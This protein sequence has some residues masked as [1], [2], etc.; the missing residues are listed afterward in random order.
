M[1]YQIAQAMSASVTYGYLVES[2]SIQNG[3]HGGTTQRT[4]LGST[5]II[6][7]DIITAIN[8]QR[9][10]NT[11]D[12]LSYLEQHTLPG[13]TVNFTVIRS[14]QQQTVSVTFGNA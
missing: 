1:N 7:G 2:V 10:A 11:D 8:N 13:Q 9:I 12:L 14:G 3:L 5:V 4:I 6:G